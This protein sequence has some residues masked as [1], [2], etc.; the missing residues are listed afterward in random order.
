MKRI[1]VFSALLFF[2]FPICAHQFQ[3]NKVE[4]NIEGC[5]AKIFGETQDYALAHQVPLDTKR[6]FNDIKELNTYLDDYR[7][8]LSNLR[9]FET[10]KVDYTFEQ[11]QE[12]ALQENE[13]TLVNLKV[14]VKD[15]F[16]LFAIPGP[17]YNSNTGLT[18]KLKIKDTNFLG[19]LN[20]LSSDVYFMIPTSESDAEHS[21]L[22]FNL[23]IDYPFQAGI[24]DATWINDLGFSYTFG[25]R[26]PEWDVKTGIKF[27]LPFEKTNLV[28]EADQKIANNFDY[29]EFGDNLYFE[30]LLKFSLPLTLTTLDYFGGLYYTPYTNASFSWDFDGISEQNS[31]LSSPILTLGHSLS[32]GRIDWENNLRNGL[33]FSL[34]NSYTWNFQRQRF[35]PIIQCDIKAYKQFTIFDDSLFL[36][37]IGLACNFV[38]FSYMFNPK[39]EKYKNYI[40]NDG[41]AIGGYLRGIRDN[42]KYA[43]T[44][45]SAL[46][47]T[48]ALILNMDFPVHIF[49]T[50]FQKSFLRYFNFDFQLSPF[51]D[52]ALCY[53]KITQT[54][55]NL[56]D[57]F[58]AAGLE[59]I[60]YPLKWSGITVRGSIGIDI[61]RKLFASKLNTS[62]RE[63]VSTREFQIG[64]GL[65]Y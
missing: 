48:S 36:R 55:F 20:T 42:Q 26:M 18:F 2:L 45:I 29:K 32:F 37:N 1:A 49:T 62:W 8:K 19:S 56:K 61:G 41:T 16:H 60:V 58:Y 40:Y 24:F 14:S 30:E 54:F 64:F 47:P 39:N 5:G 63:D 51:I 44:D 59:V 27:E 31:A 6:I 12:E 34:N 13:I 43:G 15:S 25:D 52:A 33:T 57:G 46:N 28:I 23:S 65:H 7:Q 11:S 9:A 17:K 10:I 22:G 21:E 35:Y 38:C 53:N 3:I 4:Y 50:N